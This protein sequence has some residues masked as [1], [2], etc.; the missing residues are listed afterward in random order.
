MIST[1]NANVTSALLRFYEQAQ[2]KKEAEKLIEYINAVIHERFSE[3]T[4]SS[5][6]NHHYDI[7]LNQIRTEISQIKL[8]TN[9][10]FFNIMLIIIIVSIVLLDLLVFR[11]S[12]NL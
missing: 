5:E 4:S 9:S 1:T 3:Y 8:E 10:K 11:H 2:N 12:I 7:K 6:E